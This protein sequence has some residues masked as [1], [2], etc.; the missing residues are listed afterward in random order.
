MGSISDIELT[1]VSG[2][3]E[4]LKGKQG[5]SVM[6]DCEF[7]I[8]DQLNLIDADLKISLF[9]KIILNFLKKRLMVTKQPLKEL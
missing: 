4:K 8:Q 5:I 7:T 6:S 3:V 9:W 1:C 2:V